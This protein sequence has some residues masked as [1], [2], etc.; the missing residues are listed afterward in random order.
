[1]FR[2][3]ALWQFG[4][5]GQNNGA[6]GAYQG[7]SAP[8]STIWAAAAVGRRHLQLR[9]RC[10]GALAHRQSDECQRPAD[11]AVHAAVSDRDDLRRYQRDGACQIHRRASESLRRLRMDSIRAAE[12]PADLVYRYLGRYH[13][14]LRGEY[15]QPERHDG[16]Q[17]HRILA[18]AVRR[19]PSATTKF[20]RSCGPERNTP[21]PTTSM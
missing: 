15:R 9:Q 10:R 7:Q 4:G 16:H 18:P 19:P 1:M 17:Q 20:C 14:R 13:L 3:A 5:Y 11:R 6:D 8:T 2:A 12:R 21:S